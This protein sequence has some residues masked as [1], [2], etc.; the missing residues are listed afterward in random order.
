MNPV[1]PKSSFIRVVTCVLLCVLIFTTL[2]TISRAQ[3]PPEIKALTQKMARG[4]KLTPAEQKQYDEYVKSLTDKLDKAMDKLKNLPTRKPVDISRPLSLPDDQTLPKENAGAHYGQSPAP[5]ESEYLGIVKKYNLASGAKLRDLKGKLDAV[6]VKASA[7]NEI[8]N[9]GM[10]M[11]LGRTKDND[12]TAAAL[13]AITAS[14]L[15]A[16][17]GGVFASNFGVMLKDIGAYEDSLHVLLYAEKH[18]PQSATVQTNLGWTIAYLGDFFTAKAHFQKAINLDAYDARA[19]EGMGLLFRVEGNL[20]EASKYLRLS[21]RSGFS[22]VAARNLT[23]IEGKADAVIATS[24]ETANADDIPGMRLSDVQ[25][26]PYPDTQASSGPA[27]G[28]LQFA[29]AP[30]FFSPSVARVYQGHVKNEFLQYGSQKKVEFKAANEALYQAQKEL[31]PLRPPPIRSGN[32]ITYPRSYEPEAFALVDLD[33][34]FSRRHLLRE[35]KFTK[36][37]QTEIHQPV[38]DKFFALQ[39]QFEAEYRACNRDDACQAAATR[40]VCRL[41]VSSIQTFNGPFQ[42]LW[43]KYVQEDRADLQRYFDYATPWLGEIKNPKLNRYMNMRREFLIKAA[44]AA[45]EV[46]VW[47]I[48]EAD[49]NNNWSPDCGTDPPPANSGNFLRNKL[50]VFVEPYGGCHVP[51]GKAGGGVG[52]ISASIEATCDSLKVEFGVAGIIGSA[53]TK[54]GEKESDDVTTFRIGTGVKAGATLQIGDVELG[55]VE[56]G[57][58]ASYFIS[59][60]NGSLIDHGVEG[61]AKAE[62]TIGNG[63]EGLLEGVLPTATLGLSGKAQISAESGPQVSFSDEPSVDFGGVAEHLPAPD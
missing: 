23:L 19:Y 50:K 7:P 63:G 43:A 35:A 11:Y 42:T 45:E 58:K 21:L 22:G 30:D 48:W 6:F 3:T 10:A 56:V 61:S 12:E 47:G 18:L 25:Q 46:G 24:P 59:T 14:A 38:V 36:R 8:A 2:P 16:P 52:I 55:N 13:Y 57:A 60:Q 51:T 1:K 37:F 31:D 49:V 15:K 4:E 44:D 54:F 27:A 28:K 5:S 32:S 33:H 62:G 9:L 34:I 41:R 17:A 29:A 53:E 40:R 26:F 20:N 39:K